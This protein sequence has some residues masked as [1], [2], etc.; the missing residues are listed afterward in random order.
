MP[1]GLIDEIVGILLAAGA[2]TRFGGDKLLASLPDGTPVALASARTLL[3]STDRALLVLRSERSELGELL[4]AHGMQPVVCQEAA[5]GMGA[6]LACGVKAA[7]DAAGWLVAL[8]DMPFLR[9]ETVS[10]VAQAVRAGALIAAPIWNG[11]RGHPVGF[12][13]QCYPALAALRGDTGAREL[14]AAHPDWITWVPCDDPGI[15][16]DIDLPSDL[17]VSIYRTC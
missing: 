5:A 11:R 2:S 1:A 10:A 14:L 9:N 13:R 8:A 4:R 3:E 15:V 7:Y 6:S 12:G 16:R 17:L